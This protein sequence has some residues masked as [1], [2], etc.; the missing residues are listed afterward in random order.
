MRESERGVARADGV[1]EE[2]F[3]GEV[4]D[5]SE[6]G[7]EED[8]GGGLEDAADE[9]GCE[10]AGGAGSGGLL[11]ECGVDGLDAEGLGRGAVHE[12]VWIH[13]RGQRSSGEGEGREWTH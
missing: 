9:A 10:D 5:V 8:H 7:A 6:K 1:H 2:V 13:A 3:G 12:D 11:E 4:G